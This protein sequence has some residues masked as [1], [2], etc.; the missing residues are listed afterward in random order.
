MDT[1]LEAISIVLETYF[2]FGFP[3][4]YAIG[5]SLSPVHTSMGRV[6]FLKGKKLIIL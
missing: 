5:D 1:L 6:E 3:N 4:T 2:G